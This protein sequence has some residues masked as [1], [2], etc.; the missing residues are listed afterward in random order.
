[1]RIKL[2][3]TLEAIAVVALAA[4]TIMYAQ[5]LWQRFSEPLAAVAVP[6]GTATTRVEPAE[7]G[8]LTDEERRKILRT[9]N[10]QSGEPLAESERTQI[11]QDLSGKQAS[12][13]GLTETERQAI[14]NSFE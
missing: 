4:V 3:V 7:S 8:S 9:L 1:M 14:I 12:S 2:F 6:T 5:V 13:T 10:E 11:L